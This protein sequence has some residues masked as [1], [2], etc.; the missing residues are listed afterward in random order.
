MSKTQTAQTEAAPTEATTAAAR[1]DEIMNAQ[2]VLYSKI[3]DLEK[4]IAALM[5]EQS[6]TAP[7]ADAAQVIT[8]AAK[9]LIANMHKGKYYWKVTG[10]SYHLHGITI[11]PEILEEAG[12][13]PDELDPLKP[14]DLAGYVATCEA[15]EK[16]NPNKVI[17]LAKA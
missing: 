3:K 15:N 8:F 16:G 17:K 6:S 10:G 9:N 7:A 12:I 14:L 5:M 1:H 11:W 2:R 13:N 4:M